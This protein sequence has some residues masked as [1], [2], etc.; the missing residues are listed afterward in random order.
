MKKSLAL[1]CA[2]IALFLFVPRVPAGPMV[3]SGVF[4]GSVP[5]QDS[6][7]ND[8]MQDV[9]GNKTDTAAAASNTTSIV[10]IIKEIYSVVSTIS[11]SI[12]TLTETGGTLTT[13]G[14]EQ[15]IYINNAPSG[16]YTP[17]NI[18]LNFTAHTAGETVVIREYYRI[19]SGGNYI[20]LDEVTFAGVQDP[21]LIHVELENNRYGIK[22]T[23]EKTVGTNRDYDY[24]VFYAL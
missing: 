23:M 8:E 15:N 24:E 17:E 13:D 9:I 11:S 7:D 2:V 6:T 5:S 21:L 4:D 14:T 3:S 19:K 12:F 10:A 16:I 20:M 22:V 1:F 18:F